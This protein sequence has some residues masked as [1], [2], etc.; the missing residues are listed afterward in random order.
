MAVKYFIQRT[1]NGGGGIEVE[2]PERS[3]SAVFND[4]EILGKHAFG[5]RLYEKSVAVVDGETLTGQAK[6]AESFMI[7]DAVTS[8]EDAMNRSTLD[9][10]TNN[11]RGGNIK[12]AMETNDYVVS[13]KVALYKGV[14]KSIHTSDTVVSPKGEV[15]LARKL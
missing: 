14:P 9:E 7:A 1:E 15:L 8:F 11:I 2:I 5:F 12:Y 3:L 4:P 6:N 13:D 10:T